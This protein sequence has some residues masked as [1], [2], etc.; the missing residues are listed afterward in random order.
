M[1]KFKE[2]KS[3]SLAEVSRTE[4]L[5]SKLLTGDMTLD[6]ALRV[7]LSFDQETPTHDASVD[8]L[9]ILKD[10]EVIE[11]FEKQSPEIIS[12]Y[13]NF[14][15]ITEFHVAQ[16]L[17]LSGD[18]Y[19]ALPYFKLALNSAEK[20][21]SERWKNYVFGTVMY[22]EGREI[23]EDIING[24]NMGNNA[25]ILKNFNKKLRQRGKPDYK[26]DY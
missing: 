20:G 13:N 1:N 19:S 10:P 6:E 21:Y 24:S 7:L 22:L 12:R 23:P 4:S 14:L 17:A 8:N 16:R 26:N 11:F 18:E 2:Q 25:E 5:K 3:Q 15:S 9:L